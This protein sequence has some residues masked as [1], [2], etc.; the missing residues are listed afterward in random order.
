ME[1][2]SNQLPTSVYFFQGHNNEIS[3]VEHI[4]MSILDVVR[5]AGP[6]QLSYL[7]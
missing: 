5:G 4:N 6:A 3:Y 1:D 2:C 7:G